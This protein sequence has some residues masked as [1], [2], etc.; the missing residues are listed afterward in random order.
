MFFAVLHDFYPFIDPTFAW[1]LRFAD[2]YA[3]LVS[4][5]CVY[6]DRRGWEVWGYMGCEWLAGLDV[7][8]AGLCRDCL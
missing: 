7:G 1:M 8:G 5:F 4:R 2:F 6:V 3:D